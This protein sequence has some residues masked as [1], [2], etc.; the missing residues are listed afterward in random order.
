MTQRYAHLRDEALIRAADVAGNLFANIEKPS[1]SID[2]E[3]PKTA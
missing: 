2:I 3:N 1:T